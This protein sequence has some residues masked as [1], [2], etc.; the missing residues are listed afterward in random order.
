MNQNCMNH[1]EANAIPSVYPVG[2]G[3]GMEA[4]ETSRDNELRKVLTEEQYQKY[5]Q[6]RQ[7]AADKARERRQQAPQQRRKAPGRG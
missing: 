1:D 7:Q 5:Q 2:L 6:N 4:I 3:P